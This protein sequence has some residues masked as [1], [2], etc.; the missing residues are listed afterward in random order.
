MTWVSHWIISF[1]KNNQINTWFGTTHNLSFISPMRGP[2]SQNGW[3]DAHTPS[4]LA[5][6]SPFQLFSYDLMLTNIAKSRAIN[7]KVVRTSP[8]TSIKK[9]KK[10][11]HTIPIYNTPTTTLHRT[12]LP[13][14][15]YNFGFTFGAGALGNYIT[16]KFGLMFL[17]RV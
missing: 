15:Q 8:I 1:L 12:L 13:C 14:P 4:L 7:V 2:S 3:K 11:I 17:L 10:S 16:G 9:V 6:A 5:L